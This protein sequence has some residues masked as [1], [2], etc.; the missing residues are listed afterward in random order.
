MTK[1]R[2]LYH[3]SYKNMRFLD[4]LS[5]KQTHALNTLKAD[6][7]VI[8]DSYIPEKKLQQMQSELQQALHNMQFNMP[9]LAQNKIDSIIHK[10]LINN[11]MLGTPQQLEEC[12]VTFDQSQAIDYE[13]VLAD[14]RPSTLTVP[15]LELSATYRETWTDPFILGIISAYLG[16]VPKLIEAYVR[17]NFPAQYRSMNHYWHR[18]INHDFH[19]LKMFV[20]LSDCTIETGPHEF[21]KG[22]HTNLDILNGQRY[23]QDEQVDKIYPLGHENRVL[24][25]VKAGTVIIENTQGLHRATIP[26]TGYRDLGYGVFMPIPPLYRHKNYHFPK[27]AYNS[28]PTFQKAFIPKSFTD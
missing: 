6:G 19:L 24:S 17:R 26:K 12:G 5:P 3:Q 18:D 28:L 11:Y 13:Q 7:C 4:P 20:F 2:I 21:I 9:C 27:N 15:M 14:F 22:S 25:T 10:D 1:S 23:F 8:L 16:M